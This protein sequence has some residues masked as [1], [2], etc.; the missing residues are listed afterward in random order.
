MFPHTLCSRTLSPSSQDTLSHSAGSLRTLPRPTSPSPSLAS[1]HKDPA[2]IAERHEREEEERKK[3]IQL[4]VFVSRC[5][6]YPFNSKQPNDMTRRQQKITKQNLDTI[7]NRF[8]V[9]LMLFYVFYV[10]F[11]V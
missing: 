9:C 6:S 11:N 4:Y 1:E 5:I 7:T 2:E 8:Q 3:R 10:C